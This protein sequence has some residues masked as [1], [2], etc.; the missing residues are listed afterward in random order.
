MFPNR[1]SKRPD[2]VEVLDGLRD[3][4]L[5]VL[6]AMLPDQEDTGSRNKR[7]AIASAGWQGGRPQE[8][9][10]DQVPRA[11]DLREKNSNKR[12]EQTLE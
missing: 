12:G 4:M 2:C 3:G 5:D 8:R 7:S 10:D 1:L 11:L 6:D 9:A